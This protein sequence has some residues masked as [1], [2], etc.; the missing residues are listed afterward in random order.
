MTQTSQ[1]FGC[2][3][4]FCRLH[5]FMSS[6]LVIRKIISITVLC[7]SCLRVVYLPCLSSS[8]FQSSYCIR[9][10]PLLP[11]SLRLLVSRLLSEVACSDGLS[12]S[13]RR[14]YAA[15]SRTCFPAVRVVV[16]V[17]LDFQHVMI[18][19]LDS[20]NS[21]CSFPCCYTAQ[22]FDP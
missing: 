19:L 2:Q 20:L 4:G 3:S 6:S 21:L 8:F 5:M 13:P 22:S 14:N 10:L 17:I 9:I 1:L 18:M 16:D 15:Q 12:S 11:S 7:S